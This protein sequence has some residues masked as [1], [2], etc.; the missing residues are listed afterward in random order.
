M[1][2]WGACV[3]GVAYLFTSWI[4]AR[5]LVL[6][7]I[8]LHPAMGPPFA[9]LLVIVPYLVGGLYCRYT[10]GGMS[11][12]YPIW[13]GLL[14]TSVERLFIFGVGYLF[15]AGGGDGTMWGVSYMNF[16]QG[17]AAPYFTWPYI[18][19]GGIISV[20]ITYIVST[21]FRGKVVR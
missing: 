12:F 14:A 21:L 15:F 20:A 3:I 8:G 4:A 10:S 17:E 18:T 19:V 7:G 6:P 11:R 13:T 9:R 1:I 16:I 2:W 5:A